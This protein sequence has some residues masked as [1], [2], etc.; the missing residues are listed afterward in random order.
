MFD[1]EFYPTPD[2]VIEMMISDLDVSGKTV[3]EPSAGSGNI[4]DFVKKLGA[5]VIACERHSDL[6]MIVSQKC[7]L[8]KSDFF[9]VTSEE[10]SHI[11]F[12]ITFSR[13]FF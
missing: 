3:L 13:T 6:Q 5:E 11:D 2:S 1:K 9:D 4:V 7:R 12:I 10:I 8:I